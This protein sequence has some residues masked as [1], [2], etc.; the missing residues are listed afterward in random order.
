MDGNT[1]VFVSG[2]TGFVD[3]TTVLGAT[4]VITPAMWLR[5]DWD[6]DGE[7]DDDPSAR[8]SFGIF[9]GD[10]VQIYIQQTYE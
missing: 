1:T 3:T 6:G 2:A 7:H 4:G 8:A 10:P 5:Y 9:D